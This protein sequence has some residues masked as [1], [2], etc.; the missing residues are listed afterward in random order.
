MPGFTKLHSTIINSSVWD[1]SDSVRIV[2][3]T[4]LAMADASGFVESSLGGLAHQARKPKE[5]TTH[6]LAVLESPDA[7]SKNPD[8]E[9]RRIKKVE[10]GWLLLNYAIYRDKQELSDDPESVASRERVRRHRERK[11]QERAAL[12]AVTE[13]LQTV[14]TI[15]SASASASESASVV[16]G[17]EVLRMAQ[18]SYTAF[19]SKPPAYP[20]QI[21]LGNCRELVKQGRTV[22]A[23]TELAAWVRRTKKPQKPQSPQTLTDPESWE[24]W[25]SA[26]A[27]D[28][29]PQQR[30]GPNI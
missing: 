3:I 15:T 12:H 10:G 28:V 11:A 16:S 8:H 9:G 24:K 2:W 4:L 23:F 22:E 13:P 26:M 6:A 30:N 19:P 27:A 29:Q 7:D 1:E 18:V 17:A 14:T 20:S 25:H 21:V 5:E